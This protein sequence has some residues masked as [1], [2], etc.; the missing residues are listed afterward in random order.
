M[1]IQELPQKIKRYMTDPIYRFEVNAR[2][3]PIS[4]EDY[5]KGVFRLKLGYELNLDYPK[6]F[7]EKL[8]WLKIHDRNPEY[9]KMV[10][11]YEVKKYVA[12]K[13]GNQYII[14]TIGVWEHFSDIDFNILPNKFVLKC[15]HDSGSVVLV[16]DKKTWEKKTAY[17]KI[18]K[19]MRRNYYYACREWCYNHVHPR[20]IAEPYLK[21]DS[22]AELVDYK[23]MCFGA[24]LNALL[25][26]ATAS[27]AT[28]SK[29][30]FTTQ[31]GK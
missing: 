15:T 22:G 24:K 29:S 13:I 8:Q 30:H 10:D 14:P 12:E 23:L 19:A 27:A 6:T 31:T 18:E 9:T 2:I 20:I 11:K 7:N 25:C 17:K 26:A 28:A 4:D 21:N 5:L 16:H 3:R 1:E